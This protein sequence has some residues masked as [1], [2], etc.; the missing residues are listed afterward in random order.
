[1]RIPRVL[2]LLVVWVVL[3]GCDRNM[4]P[5]VPGEKPQPPD[6]AKI[7]PAGAERPS[8]AERR[9]AAGPTGG[10]GAA[11]M[12]GQTAAPAS[13]GGEAIQG[14][15]ELAEGLDERIPPGAV[16]FLIART[17][18][19]GP[20][21]AVKRIAS[22]SFPFAFQIGPDDRMIQAMPFVGPIQI[23]ARVDRDGDARTSDAGDLQGRAAA[24]VEPGATGVVVRV[25]EAL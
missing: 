11:P 18:A 4:E 20:P 9:P 24:G 17:G 15:V 6:L 7:F 3:G 19:G 23:S 2:L 14:T 21:L 13:A 22:P 1:M 12:G 16:L 8:A 10:R 5:F 25:D